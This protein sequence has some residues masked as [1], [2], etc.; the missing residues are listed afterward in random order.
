MNKDAAVVS[1]PATKHQLKLRVRQGD[2]CMIDDTH[3]H[4]ENSSQFTD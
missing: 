3:I 2:G 4:V 1:V